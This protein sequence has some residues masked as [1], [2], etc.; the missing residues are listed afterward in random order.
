MSPRRRRLVVA[1]ARTA[2][3][4]GAR[5]LTRVRV[6]AAS[7]DGAQARDE[8]TGGDGTDWYFAVTDAPAGDLI[9]DFAAGERRN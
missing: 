1:L 4:F 8:L 3:G 6:L 9:T 7:G 2:A 5:I